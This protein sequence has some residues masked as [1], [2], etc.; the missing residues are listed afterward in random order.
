MDLLFIF[1]GLCFM[2]LGVIGSFLPI[3]PG[4]PLSWIGLLML[5]IT[6]AIPWDWTFLSITFTIA[7]AVTIL[8]YWI[9]A[10]GVKKFGGSKQ[11]MIGSVIGLIV[12]LLSPIPFGIIIGTFLGAYAG[13]L[14]NNA[15]DRK[16][17]KSATGALLGFLASSLMKFVLSLIYFGLFIAQIWQFR[18]GLL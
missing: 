7:L 17:S 8:D 12:G 14:L 9:P 3:L 13:E 4:P 5:S 11:S 1:I 6:D 18:S 15:N 2:I 16:A 10:L